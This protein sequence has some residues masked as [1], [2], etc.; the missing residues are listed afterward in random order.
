MH[1]H[2][3][4]DV[5]GAAGAL[6]EALV[7]TCGA[8]V[9][10]DHPPDPGDPL[11]RDAGAEFTAPLRARLSGWAAPP[12]EPEAASPAAE[13]TLLEAP[14]A[15]AEARGV[16]E[17]VRACLDAGAPPERIGIVA[18]ALGP[19]AVP[20]RR[21]LARL[22]VPFSGGTGAAHLARPGARVL[23]S[24]L[25]LLREGASAPVDGW[26]AARAGGRSATRSETIDLRVALHALG[27]GRLGDVARLDVAAR[28]G[29]KDHLALPVRQG[30]RT[31]PAEAGDES[32]AK[33]GRGARAYLKRRTLSAARLEA[34]VAEARETVLLLEAWP[35]RASLA[36]RRERLEAL[37]LR[38]LRWQ[39]ASAARRAVADA[40]DAL[41]LEVP[42]DF[43]LDGPEAVLLLERMLAGAESE[44][45]GG[46][47][48]GVAVLSVTEARAHTFEHLFLVGVNRDVFPRRISEDPLPPDA[49]R[50]AL[51]AVLPHVPR[52]GRGFEEERY[53]FAQLCAAS[54]RVTLSWQGVS[55]DGRARTPSPF[56]ERLRLA[57]LP[58]EPLPGVLAEPG[59]EPR[60]RPAFEH[61]LLAGLHGSE[62][63]REAGYAAALEEAR[64]ELGAAGAVPAAALARTRAAARREWEGEPGS[65]ALGPYLGLVGPP[66]ADDLRGRDLFV[67][68]LEGMARC[69][70]RHFL[71]KLLGLEPVPDALGWLPGP[72]PLLL[73][74]ALHG[75]VE[76]IVRAGTGLPA[77]EPL[78]DALGREPRSLVWPGPEEAARL[79]LGAVEAVLREQGIAL[80]GYAAA[81]ARPVAA[82]A[83]RARELLGPAPRVVAAEALGAAVI[84]GVLGEPLRLHFKVDIALAGDG[85]GPV[86]ADLKTGA[87]VSE[88]S[89]AATRRAH[90]VGKVRQGLLLQGMAY[91][92]AADGAIGRYLFLGEAARPEGRCVE[93]RAGDEELAGVFRS[94]LSELVAARREGAFLPRLL[95]PGG[96]KYADHCRWCEVR[97]ACVHGDSGMRARLGR[98]SAEPGRRPPAQRRAPRASTR[99][100]GPSGAW[101]PGGEPP[102]TDRGRPPG[103][104][105]GPAPLRRLPRARG[106]RR[107][108]QDHGPRQ[109]GRRLVPRPGLGPLGGRARGAAASPSRAGCSRGSWR[110]PSPRPPPPRWSCASGSRCARSRPA[111]CPSG[112][113]PRG[114]RRRPCAPSGR[115]ASWRASTSSWSS[116]STRS[117]AV[118]WRPIPSKRPSTRASR[119][120][121]TARGSGAACA[122]CSSSRS[123]AP[124]PAAA[125]ATS[126]AC[127]SR[128]RAPPRSRRA[129]CASSRRGRRRELLEA[130]VHTPPRVAALRGELARGASGAP[131]GGGRGLRTPSGAAED[132]SRS[133]GRR[134]SRAR[135]GGGGGAGRGRASRRSP[136]RCAEPGRTT[137]SSACARGRRASSTP[138]RR[139]RS[140]VAG[141][142]CRPPPAACDRCC[143]TS[144]AST[145]RSSSGRAAPSR[146]CCAT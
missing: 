47:G 146:R 19:Y 133:D 101:G 106:R 117:A 118:S 120:T 130:E 125:T 112:S 121:A 40:L 142:S 90:L 34:A 89:S 77:E 87:V 92:H 52:K 20:L 102:R 95:D 17:R 98:W 57:G 132:G 63:E 29:G 116:R 80:P 7:R 23:R 56:I 143:A 2:G 119:S 49:L 108:G 136:R 70:W 65:A 135:R 58:A 35:E 126:R 6:L 53:L 82:A 13:L 94:A 16:A 115:G 123:C 76:A 141:P 14:G 30:L 81:L 22:A 31:A 138:A 113:S 134:A 140:A 26:L 46:A 44:G 139:T 83:E 12:R 110:S 100:C 109:P 38:G 24:L 1:V 114:S 131:R 59:P 111:S 72:D 69:P 27:A 137:A 42:G 96:R 93:V 21:H 33:E 71:E 68:Q 36:L 50:R 45:I 4:A 105:G 107:H 37:A 10:L 67:T 25:D 75:A 128:T 73:G 28:L 61:A 85:E 62:A 104:G 11:R 145:R 3:F 66:G 78:A 60:L 9:V 8:R 88:A 129:S 144:R 41:A 43:G 51:E 103:A 39:P 5:T 122:R 18:R 48:G 91:A 64:R 127:V 32:G 54:P 55:E 15:D 79:V 97:D 124:S 84:P 86:L 99:R 74:S